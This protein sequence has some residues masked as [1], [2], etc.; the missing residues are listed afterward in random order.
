MPKAKKAKSTALPVDPDLEEIQ[1][2]NREVRERRKKAREAGK[3]ASDKKI[4]TDG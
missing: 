2:G 4:R 1:A 3:N